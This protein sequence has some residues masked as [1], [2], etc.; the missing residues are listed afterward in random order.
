MKR[1]FFAFMALALVIMSCATA[2]P[3][4]SRTEAAVTNTTVTEAAAAKPAVKEAAVTEIPAQDGL[5]AAIRRASDYINKNV[6]RG[7]KLVI[8]NIKSEYAP[9]S[10][11]VIDVLTGNVVNDR[12]FTVVDR[13]NL[14]LIQQEMEFQLSGEV[15]DE[16]AQSIGQKLGAQTIVSGSITPFG[17]LWR[18]TVRALGVKD[19]TVLGLLNENIP[20]SSILAALTGGPRTPARTAAASG[21]TPNAGA[22]S[23]AQAAAP[24]QSALPSPDGPFVVGDTGPARGVV[25]YDAA[26]SRAAKTPPPVDREYQVG[27]TGPAGGVIFYINPRAGDWKYL[28]AAPATTEKQ[29]FWCAEEFSVDDIQGARSVGTGKSNSDYIMRQA[30][31]R[32]GGFDWAAEI[33]DSL[34][35][36]GY[37]D[38]FLPSRDELHQMYGNLKRIGLGG[39]KDEAYWSSTPNGIAANGT[40]GVWYENFSNGE[41]SYD[42]HGNTYYGNREQKYRV[43]A[44]RQF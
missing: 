28:E 9:L 2:R 34:V 42:S 32:G 12:V 18:L 23:G 24:A 3:G 14:A 33:C 11:Y 31:D 29:T 13:A 38:W 6:P 40:V 36:N 21:T 16:S 17:D 19:A 26:Y 44:I 37:D 10:E 25:F 35:V 39:F 15:S 20:S 4:T 41:Q 27:D 43:R 1:N 7:S 30:I 22:A 5:D 8:L